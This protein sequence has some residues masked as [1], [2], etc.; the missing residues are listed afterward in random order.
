[1]S[2]AGD[3]LLVPGE[4]VLH[5]SKPKVGAAIARA[6]TIWQFWIPIIGQI[7]GLNLV[8]SLR[9]TEHIITSRRIISGEK[10]M[11]GRYQ[12]EEINLAAIE[13]VGMNQGFIQGFFNEGNIIIR[14]MSGNN[15]LL[16]SRVQEPAEFRRIALARI[17]ELQG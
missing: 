10:K 7:M 8:L 16:L 9:N 4:T 17:D 14:S 3:G 5:R 15:D 11:F 1:M 2:W 12:W 13:S 6:F